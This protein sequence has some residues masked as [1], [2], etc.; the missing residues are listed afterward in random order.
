MSAVR[1]LI[2]HCYPAAGYESG[3]AQLVDRWSVFTGR[4]LVAVM[5]GQGLARIDDVMP[6]FPRETEFMAF[7]NNPLLGESVSFESLLRGISSTSR[8][9]ITFYAHSKG[10]SSSAAGGE[11]AEAVKLWARAMY[12]HNLRDPQVV[13]SVL[14]ASHTAGVFR[15]LGRYPKFPKESAWHYSGSFCWFRNSAIF[16]Q[17]WPRKIVPSR[18]CSEFFFST[19][20][21]LEHSACL[22]GDNL[23]ATHAGNL[24]R[25][26]VVTGL[27]GLP[28]G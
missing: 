4:K 18:Y 19:L 26:P 7:R 5:S 3:V 12:Y 1:N 25:L 23:P 8:E 2:Y 27:A 28:P 24:Y 15:R 20:V 13:D 11:R 17:D 22:H 9:S 10:V 6:R 16:G 14:S 21:P